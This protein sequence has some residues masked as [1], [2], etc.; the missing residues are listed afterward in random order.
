MVYNTKKTAAHLNY[1]HPVVR[2]NRV[3][4]SVSHL[5]GF[6]IVGSIWI[7]LDWKLPWLF[8]VIY[9]FV[10]PQ[11]AFYLSKNSI[12]QKGAEMRNLF[13]D[14]I[15]VGILIVSVSFQPWPITYLFLA[16]A[17]ALMIAGGIKLFLRGTIFIIIG[18][19]IGYLLLGFEFVIQSK[20]QTIIASSLG[21]AL[22]WNMESFLNFQLSRLVIN[23]KKEMK[24][25]NEEM[26]GLAGKLAKYLSP[27]VYGS[28]FSGEK[29]VKIETSRKN[30]TIFFSD[31]KDFTSISDSMESEGI[32]SLLNTYFNEMSKIALKHGG[33]IDKFIGDAIMIFFGDPKSKGISNDALSC[34]SM[35][36]EMREQMTCLQKEWTNLGVSQPLQIRMGI[37]T[38]FC[39]VG[40]FGSD[41]RMDYTIIGNQ[42]NLTSRL[43]SNAEP[44][45][46][47]LSQSTYALIKKEINCEKKEEIV[48][49]GLSYPIQTYQVQDF[50]DK[51]NNSNDLFKKEHNG[52]SLTVDFNVLT[53]EEAK[54]WLDKVKDE[55][56]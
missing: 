16:P 34:V 48:V 6:I 30:L 52:I 35:A 42:V 40:N 32:T 56:E 2:A 45:Q 54:K 33:T 5:L 11:A 25:K 12:D 55:L 51:I 43:E 20:T 8:L 15:F 26:E 21:I 27:Q 3:G 24:K 39:T 41:D 46:I 19:L 7:N 23:M 17:T 18:I 22:F 29:D 1:I 4:R 49:K 31:I 50:H 36:I 47:L 53:K 9:S 13:I 14:A 10:W 44:D 37:N 38:G 28:I